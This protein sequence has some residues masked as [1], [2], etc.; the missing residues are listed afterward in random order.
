MNF[1]TVGT[2]VEEIF[3]TIGEGVSSFITVIKSAITSI[4]QVF[5]DS[6]TGFTFLGTLAIITV[7]AGLGWAIVRLIRGSMRIGGRV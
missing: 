1:L 2:V 5:W 3:G 6:S 4:V 7:C